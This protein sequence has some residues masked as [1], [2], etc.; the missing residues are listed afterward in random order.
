MKY[1]DISWKILK[2]I[3]TVIFHDIPQLLMWESFRVSWRITICH[4]L[5]NDISER[6]RACVLSFPTLGSEP[7]TRLKGVFLIKCF[8]HQPAKLTKGLILLGRLTHSRAKVK[9]WLHALWCICWR[10]YLTSKQQYFTN[11]KTVL[12]CTC[13]F[14]LSKNLKDVGRFHTKASFSI[15]KGRS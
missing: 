9:G 14:L 10:T 4:D 12:K 7:L 2:V 11:G 8:F 5:G 3:E 6:Q 15:L 1:R 13:T